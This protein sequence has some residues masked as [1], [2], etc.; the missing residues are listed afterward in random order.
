LKKK[1]AII[2]L[3]VIAFLLLTGIIATAVIRTVGKSRLKNS[4]VDSKPVIVTEET[5]Q[6]PPEEKET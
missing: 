1:I 4:V 6:A 3:S 2:T 5:M